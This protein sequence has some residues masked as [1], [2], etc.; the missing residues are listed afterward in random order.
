MGD[1]SPE[2]PAASRAGRNLPAA[3]GSGVALGVIVVVS[4][5]FLPWLFVVVV[6]ATM[7]VAVREV[8]DAF[9][10]VG[11]RV[12]R[13][14]AYAATLVVPAVAYVW[15][16]M[17]LLAATGVAILAALLWRLR[18]GY[19]G[20][21]RDVTASIFT[22]AY[23]P[24]MAGFLS[25]T[26]AADDGPA[27]VVVFILLTIGNDIGGYAAGVLFGRHPIAPQISPKKSWEGFAGSIVV[28]GVIGALCFT[29]IFDAPWWQGVVVGLILTVTATAG[30]FAE[31][32][33]KRDLGVKDMGSFLP[34]HGGMMDRFDSLIPNA[35]TSWALFTL[36][37]G[38][39]TA[40]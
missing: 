23:L 35:F 37:L 19:E 8:V 20:Y 6:I 29:L 30:D 39:G 16:P 26:L 17:A 2:S 5:A 28:Q 27:R 15:G 18:R 38:S 32:A 10:G 4:L 13:T 36:F 34:G 14:P 21:V 12:A 24:F 9:A 1:S 33:I 31:S 25:L 3:I 40:F 22:I 7:L 11:V